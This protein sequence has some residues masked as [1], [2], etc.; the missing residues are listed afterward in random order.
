M[1]AKAFK[2]GFLFM[3]L[4]CTPKLLLAHNNS[5]QAFDSAVFEGQVVEDSVLEEMRGGFVSPEGI[6]VDIGVSRSISIDGVLQN[7][8]SYVVSQF[9]VNGATF[10][11]SSPNSLIQNKLD[12][13]AID[14]LTTLNVN[15]AN[16]QGHMQS[17]MHDLRSSQD[18]RASQEIQFLK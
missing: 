14:A 15:V 1:T 18:L 3:V 8:S 6:K 17:F 12:N 5:A 13:K 10:S 11:Y 4:V 16:Y 9:Q 7:P 2:N